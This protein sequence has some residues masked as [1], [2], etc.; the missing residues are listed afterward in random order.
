MSRLHGKLQGKPPILATGPTHGG[1]DAGPPVL[2]DFSTNAHPLGPP[3]GAL[4]D[5]VL[6]FWLHILAVSALLM[7]VWTW[8][9]TK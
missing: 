1:T 8:T 7:V 5:I 4:V 2:H 9:R 6:F 3:P